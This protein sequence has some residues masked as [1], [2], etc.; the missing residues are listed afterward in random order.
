MYVL[1]I[2]V[3]GTAFANFFSL[4]GI[5]MPLV[6][7]EVRGD[8]VA[9]QAAWYLAI[10]MSGVALVL[11]GLRRGLLV[12]AVVGS[13]VMLA[14]A[15]LGLHHVGNQRFTLADSGWHCKGDAPRFCVL[16]ESRGRLEA[17]YPSLAE[18]DRRWRALATAP[19]PDAY[20]QRLDLPV[21]GHDAVFPVSGLR[22]AERLVQGLVTASYPCSDRWTYE[23]YQSLVVVTQAVLGD[24]LSATGWS[25][26]ARRSEVAARIAE[27]DC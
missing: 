6:G 27:L 24:G 13:S 26:D 19:T 17:A 25:P 21:P 4:G 3:R 5:G 20:W 12:F 11:A 10:L 22:S 16:D 7:I 8:V 2:N 14:V 18:A 9:W 23:Q 1:L 15:G